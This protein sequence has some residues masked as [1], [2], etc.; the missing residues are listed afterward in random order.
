MSENTRLPFGYSFFNIGIFYSLIKESWIMGHML[1]INDNLY[2]NTLHIM[3]INLNWDIM[4][5][6]VT[7]TTKEIYDIGPFSSRNEAI[8]FWINLLG[9]LTSNCLTSKQIK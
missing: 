3:S 4:K 2:V 9:W 5:I 8:V 6:V 7:T 1:R